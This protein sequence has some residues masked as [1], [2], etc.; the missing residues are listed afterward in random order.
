[1]LNKY[2]WKTYIPASL[3][4]LL[5]LVGSLIPSN[6]IPDIQFSDKLIHVIFYA[7]FAFLLFLAV[8]QQNK[9]TNTLVS[10]WKSVLLIGVSAGAVVEL[11]QMSFTESRSGEWLDVIAN[12]LGMLIALIIAE[13]LKKN[14]TL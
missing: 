6:N 5:I 7:I 13:K 14:G 2:T 4:F 12:I 3:W 8:D 10:R 9:K 1:V 11:I